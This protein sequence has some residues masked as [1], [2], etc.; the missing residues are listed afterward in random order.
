MNGFR[1]DIGGKGLTQLFAILL[2]IACIPIFL[3]MKVPV[4]PTLLILG[5]LA[6]GVGGL[7]PAVIATAFT[8]IFTEKRILSSVF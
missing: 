6:G 7:A 3:K 1:A 8:A 4:G 2:A 5:A